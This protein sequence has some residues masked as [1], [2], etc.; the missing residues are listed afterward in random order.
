MNKTLLTAALVAAIGTSAAAQGI[1][2]VTT[3]PATDVTVGTMTTD[4]YILIGVAAAIALAVTH[5][6]SSDGTN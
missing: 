4:D 6:G 1:Q 2:P 5:A 3:A